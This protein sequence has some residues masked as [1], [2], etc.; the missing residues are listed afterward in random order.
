MNLVDLE[1]KR[2]EVKVMTRPNM[3]RK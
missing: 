1:V 3:V 2:S